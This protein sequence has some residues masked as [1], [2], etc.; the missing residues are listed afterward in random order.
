MGIRENWRR[1]IGDSECNNHFEVEF[2]CKKKES[3]NGVVAPTGR[4]VRYSF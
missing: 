3:R 1:E 4:Q 2:Q